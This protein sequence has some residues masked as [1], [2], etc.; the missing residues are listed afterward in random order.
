MGTGIGIVLFEMKDLAVQRALAFADANKQLRSDTGVR[1]V[2]SD[3]FSNINTQHDL[4][5]FNPFEPSEEHLD[6]LKRFL[7][8][9]SEFLSDQGRMVLL[10]RCRRFAAEQTLLAEIPERDCLVVVR[11]RGRRIRSGR[12]VLRAVTSER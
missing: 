7:A 11:E 5:I 3:L 6:V 4:I 2:R 9:G 8:D 12:R 10:I 1:F